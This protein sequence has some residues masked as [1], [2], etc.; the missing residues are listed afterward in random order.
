MKFRTV[1]VDFQLHSRALGHRQALDH[2]QDCQ[3]VYSQALG[4][5]QDCQGVYSRALGHSQNCPEI[6]S[7]DLGLIRKALQIL[8]RSG[9]YR[10]D[11]IVFLSKAPHVW[12]SL[13][14]ASERCSGPCAFSEVG[15]AWIAQERKRVT[16]ITQEMTFK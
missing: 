4:H 2:S 9:L 10:E 14:T 15:E 12:T 6:Y 13:A 3:G 7:Q 11:P 1:S 5:G 8:V 16:H